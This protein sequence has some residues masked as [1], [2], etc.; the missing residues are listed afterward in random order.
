M[1]TTMIN[2]G[3]PRLG[4]L[5]FKLWTEGTLTNMA[6]WRFVNDR[7]MVPRIIPQFLGYHH[8]GHLHQIWTERMHSLVYYRQTGDST[9]YAQAPWGWY[10]GNSVEDHYSITYLDRV[11][12]YFDND[13]F[14]P[15]HFVPISFW[16][17]MQQLPMLFFNNY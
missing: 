2:F 17:F 5:A 4:N 12:T 9:H 1:N 8:A 13:D 11:I 10:Y 14:W 3:A 7:D 6:A 16:S 15:D